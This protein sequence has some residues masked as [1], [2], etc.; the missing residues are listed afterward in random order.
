MRIGIALAAG[1][2][3]LALGLAVNAPATL[4]DVR[5]NAISGGRV[6]LA[7]ASGTLWGGS[8]E[9]WLAPGFV[10]RRVDWHLAAW[11]LLWGEARGTLI[12]AGGEPR[13]NFALG[14]KG[15]ALRD[16]ALS[17]PADALVGV[18]GALA[19]LAS[20]S[21][22]LS[23]SADTLIWREDVVEGRVAL[24][25]NGASLAGPTPDSRISLGEVRLDG[26][27]QA[28]ALSGKVGNAGG[29]VDISGSMSLSAQ[30]ARVELVVRPRSELA[31]ERARAIA[32]ALAL[33]GQ[34]E[35]ANGYRLAWSGSLL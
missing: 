32:A 11:P 26:I 35:A 28:N 2:L 18:F 5:L 30:G 6:R 14:N 17:M 23:L 21:G 15:F 8:G 24:R 12:A 34:P 31:P 16:V 22:V 10:A 29:D 20:A 19:P 27:G 25:W 3:F 13:A 4:I 9:V 33:L 7:D 1:V